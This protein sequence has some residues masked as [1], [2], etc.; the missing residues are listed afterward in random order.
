MSFSILMALLRFFRII[1]AE[2][3]MHYLDESSIIIYYLLYFVL[4]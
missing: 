4:L 2:P 1:L 3:K